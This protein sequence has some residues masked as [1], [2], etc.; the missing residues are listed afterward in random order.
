MIEIAE[1]ELFP[2]WLDSLRDAD[3]ATQ[4]ADIRAAERLAKK[5]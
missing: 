4:Q 2:S 1:P 5:V 3:K